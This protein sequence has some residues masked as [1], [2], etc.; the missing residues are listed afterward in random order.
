MKENRE[1]KI[2]NAQTSKQT[3][4]RAF[5]AI[6]TFRNGNSPRILGVFYSFLCAKAGKIE[7]YGQSVN[8]QPLSYRREMQGI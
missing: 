5:Q 6:S 4:R 3:I 8:S 7:T 1:E 2:L